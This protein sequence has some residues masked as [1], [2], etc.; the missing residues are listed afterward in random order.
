VT[1]PTGARPTSSADDLVWTIPN[2]LSGLRLLGVPVFLVLVLGPHHDRVAFVLLM[3]SGAS[4]YFDGK[5]ARR[6][7]QVS[8][9]GT[10]LDPLADRLYIASTVLA[11]VIRGA[12]PLVLLLVLLARDLYLAGLLALLRR[13]GWAPP[14]VSYVGKAATLNLLYAFPLLLLALGHDGLAT[15]ARPVGWAFTLWGT[16][17]YLV[18]GALYTVQARRLLGHVLG[19]Q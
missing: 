7:G 18:A 5:L 16:A 17:L 13:R 15:F 3:A 10:L 11:L 9:L 8:R 19:Q 14:A 4:D 6:W 1:A 2:L 12:V